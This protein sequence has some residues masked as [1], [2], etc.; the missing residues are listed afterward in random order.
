MAEAV[1]EAALLGVGEHRVRL[2]RFL[3][4]LL[5]RLVA[6]IAIRVV[7]HRQLAV[8][9]LD[10]AVGRACARRRGFRSSRACSRL[11]HLHHRRPQQP[12]AEHV[13]ALQLADHFALAMIG[14]RLR[15]SPPGARSDRSRRRAPRSACTPLLAQQVVQLRVDQLDAFAIRRRLRRR[16]RRSARDRSRRRRAAAPAAGRRPPD[17][18]ARAARARRACGSC[19]TRRSCAAG[20]RSSRRARAAV[21]SSDVRRRP[22]PSRRQSVVGRRSRPPGCV[23]AFVSHTI[24]LIGIAQHARHGLRGAVDDG[25]RA[26]I[27]HARRPDDADRAGARAVVVRRRDQA[28]RTAGSDRDARRR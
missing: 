11:R 12:V 1:V 21:A 22:S 10:L 27:A 19:R 5:G 18:P 7:L 16:R 2:G 14:A 3:E 20:G 13:A 8:R 25:D 9:A 24:G 4:L 23:R 15:A 28:E 17:R 6:R 26:R